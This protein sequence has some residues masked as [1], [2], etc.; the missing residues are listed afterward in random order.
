MGVG[1]PGAEAGVTGSPVRAVGGVIVREDG[2][3]LLVKR[4]RPP[5]A[6]SWSIPGGHVDGDETLEAAIA[7]EVLE[8]TRLRVRVV[9]PLGVVRISHEGARYDIHEFLCAIEGHADASAGDDAADIAWADEADLARLEVSS[10]AIG[11]IDRGL[12]L[13]RRRPAAREC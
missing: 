13:A 8:E 6:G 12:R 4:A 5:R 3:V 2:R 10:K 7:R 1:V 9:A 11:V